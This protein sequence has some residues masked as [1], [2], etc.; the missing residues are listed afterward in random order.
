[1]FT[2][3]SGLLERSYLGRGRSLA[4]SRLIFEIGEE[5]AEIRELRHRLGLDSGYI[6]RLLRRLER[7]SLVTI[8]ADSR[9]RRVRHASLT[10]PGKVELNMLNTLSDA[11][12]REMLDRVPPAA[13][14]AI[15][16]AFSVLERNLSASVF[17]VSVADVRDSRSRR[18]LAAYYGEL[19]ARFPSGFNAGRDDGSDR[20]VAPHGAFLTATV[21]RTVIGCGGIAF[22]DDFAEIKRMWVDPD[23]RGIGVA[24]RILRGLEAAAIAAGNGTVRLDTNV[25]L[26]EARAF[27]AKEGYTEIGRYNDNPYATHWFE[28]TLDARSSAPESGR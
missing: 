7:E 25:A 15:V 12:A 24:T 22:E 8:V 10:D 16:D 17:D 5:G 19:N 1:M 28:K 26:R 4:A 20:F 2:Q 27:Y 14:L 3:M 18:A 9:D 11:A 6:S 21:G 13:S 23:Y